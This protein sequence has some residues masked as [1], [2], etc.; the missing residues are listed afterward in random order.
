M[1]G[2]RSLFPLIPLLV[3]ACGQEPASP[4]TGYTLAEKDLVPEGIDYS[5]SRDNFYV[6]S[7]AKAKI[8]EADHQRPG[9]AAD[10]PFDGVRP[11][12]GDEP[13]LHQLSLHL[14]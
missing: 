1:K 9:G 4:L 5:K 13:L 8:I 3:I 6:S 12:G 2:Y 10:Q 11:S 7:V 14:R